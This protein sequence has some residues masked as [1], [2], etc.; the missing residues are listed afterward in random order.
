MMSPK[1][2]PMREPTPELLA[3]LRR[4]VVSATPEPDNG[5]SQKCICDACDRAW[6]KGRDIAYW[7][8]K[9]TAQVPA[10]LDH[11]ETLTAERDAHAAECGGVLLSWREHYEFQ[12]TRAEKAEAELAAERGRREAENREWNE[13]H[14][15]WIRDIV[16]ERNRAEAA[17]EER[18]E[19]RKVACDAVASVKAYSEELNG[20]PTEH[21]FDEIVARW[22]DAVPSCGGERRVFE[23]TAKEDNTRD[24]L[25]WGLWE[26]NDVSCDA[27]WLE[28]LEGKRVRLTVEVLPEP[29]KP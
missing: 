19:A 15:L 1:E 24:V 8:G 13:Q 11:I 16:A 27:S 28:D 25:W 5:H 12:H 23:G 26:G 17:E 29:E 20:E 4:L 21:T 7:Q 2:T 9:L 22:N 6:K 3:E 10:L 14:T 18:D